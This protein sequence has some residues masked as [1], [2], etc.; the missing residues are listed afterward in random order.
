MERGLVVIG[1]ACAALACAGAARKSGPGAGEE[2]KRKGA[3]TP[4]EEVSGFDSSRLGA[5]ALKSPAGAGAET[6][7]D[8]EDVDG[9]GPI[10]KITATLP[11]EK[12]ALAVREIRSGDFWM[13]ARQFVV[14]AKHFRNAL[15]IDAANFPIRFRLA[16][17]LHS[18]G[19]AKGAIDEVSKVIETA[20]RFVAA[21]QLLADIYIAQKDLAKAEE[22]V[23]KAVALASGVP[24]TELRLAQ[25]LRM[26]A[27]A[28]SGQEADAQKAKAAEILARLE[29]R[30]PS[31][32]VVG[33]EVRRELALVKYGQIGRDFF[34]AG[35]ALMN[36]KPADALKKLDEIVAKQKDFV[37]AH[38]L[39]GVAL[40]SAKVNRSADAIESFKVAAK[41]ESL[42]AVG[43]I[44]YERAEMEDAEAWFKK[45]IALDA[46]YQEAHYALGLVYKELGEYEKAVGAWKQAM[47]ADRNSK[48]GKWAATKVQV[49]TGKLRAL[50]E[51]EVV[52]PATERDIGQKFIETVSREWGLVDDEVQQK[53]IERIVARLVAV[54]DRGA[55]SL[56]WEVRIANKPAINAVCF[57]GG[58]ILVFKGMLDFVKQ[59]LDDSDD[60]IAGVLGHEIAHASL[61]HGVNKAKVITARTATT[62]LGSP[63][64][65]NA[66]MNGFSRTNEFEADQYGVLY[67][68][69]AG[70]DPVAAMR[71]HE[72]MLIKKEIP[73]G[74]GH[75]PH[76][77]RITRLRDY[78]LELRGKTRS[79]KLGLAALEKGDNARAVHHFELFLGVFPDS[80]AARNNLGLALHRK[81]LIKV[82][83]GNYKK[84]TDIDPTAKAPVIRFRA[85]DVKRRAKSFSTLGAGPVAKPVIDRPLLREAVA[86][87]QI[88]LKSDPGYV[89]AHVNLGAAILDLDVDSDLAVSHLQ[90]ALRLDPANVHA[91]C[92]LA[93]A[94]LERGQRDIGVAALRKL[95]ADKAG[96]A[97]AH[98]NLAVAHDRAD[99]KSDAIKSY[100]RFLEIDGT[101]GWAKIARAR[102]AELSK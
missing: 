92:N 86:E 91:R 41:R 96:F 35:E 1:V 38:H 61:R 43:Q 101:S 98:F 94:N 69:R 84:S 59:E 48:I 6:L 82:P 7:V 23:T 81:A 18:S 9:L 49:L 80:V 47:W 50:A 83:Q 40:S 55:E 45:A 75:P 102:V 93:V 13:N 68:Y 58:K 74:L 66:F 89:A 22:A 16:F 71:Y 79:F 87:L 3:E 21:Y 57:P 90:T 8:E 85:M 97:D 76:A 2:A 24:Q 34:E 30:V 26:R 99:E 27:E 11:T 67:A 29:K 78:L 17:C 32:S 95:V 39:R 100:G 54:S 63:I 19:D 33:I 14:A 72:R 5:S 10:A 31:R 53:R 44:Y 88:A 36:G 12:R 15:A 51:G 37:D 62:A 77:E 60:A 65:L 56:R 25:I 46:K 70:F 20:P 4:R 73:Q 52:D 42:L 28:G 64:M